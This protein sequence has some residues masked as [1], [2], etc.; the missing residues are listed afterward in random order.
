M[1]HLIPIT[2]ASLLLGA[3][4]ALAANPPIRKAAVLH[5]VEV[6]KLA[7]GFEKSP[8]FQA[9]VDGPRKSNPRLWLKIEAELDLE[10][11]ARNH[12]IPELTA[13][14][15]IVLHDMFEDKSVQL[16]TPI[17]SL[18]INARDGRMQLV[19]YLHPDTVAMITGD[20]SP[21]DQLVKAAAVE[22]SGSN[23]S[24]LGKQRAEL[25][26]SGGTSKGKRWWDT[27]QHKIMDRSIL[28]LTE[29]PFLPIWADHYPQVNPR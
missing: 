12:F 16:V 25:W 15:R 1:K 22:V 9:Q 23:V 11:T 8:R 4:L 28:P 14:W 29:T 13:I 26:K 17:T 20:D 5:H 27:W 10:T 24:Q 7:Y 18:N 3:N 19:A 6:K 2:L 21:T